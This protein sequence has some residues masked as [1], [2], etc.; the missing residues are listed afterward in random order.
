MS[1]YSFQVEQTPFKITGT[2]AHMILWLTALFFIL[3]LSWAYLA[4]IDEITRAPGKVI[5]SQKIQIIQ[6]LEDGIIKEI[7]VREGQIVDKNQILAKLSNVQFLST[8]RENQSRLAS[9]QIQIQRL[10]A[11]LSNKPFILSPEL[12]KK[13][14]Q[15]AQS[16]LLL[17]HSQKQEL[18]NLNRKH[19]LL[20][21]EIAMTKPLVKEGAASEVE[22]LRLQQI[23]HD[24]DGAISRFKSLALQQLNETRANYLRLKENNLA[25]EDRLKRTAIRS[26]I[27][28]VVKQIYISTIGGVIKSGMPLME[29][30][31][32]EDTLLVEARVKP[33]DI[34][35]LHIGQDAMIKITA[36]DFAIY[37]G[38]PGKVE[39]I[40]AD[41]SMDREGHSFYEIRVRTQRNYLEKANQKLSIIPGMQASVDIITGKKSILNYLLHPIFR[42]KERALTER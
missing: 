10:Q 30:V 11:Q 18:K 37:G 36:Y 38:L 13:S 12:Q 15:L 19:E 31:P 24:I 25:L 40:S 27:K 3:M 26:P 33:Q 32:F 34:G 4:K 2:L 9:L 22:L 17:Y 42:A 29:I 7:L 1:E 23:V 28:G 14:P 39:Y 20:L 6:N 35:F 8:Y 21:K 16:E 41:T 5:P